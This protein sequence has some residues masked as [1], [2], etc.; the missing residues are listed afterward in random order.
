MLKKDKV[1]FKFDGEM[2]PDVA[3]NEEYKD[4]YHYITEISGKLYP[5]KS[6]IEIIKAMMTGGSLIGCPKIFCDRQ[7]DRPGPFRFGARL[8][9]MWSWA[10]GFHL[11]R[12]LRA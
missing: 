2:Q 4:L 8:T 6:I 1:D 7:P 9:K 12:H 10:M 11:D 5:Q 3:M